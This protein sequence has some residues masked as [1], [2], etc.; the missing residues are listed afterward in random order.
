MKLQKEKLPW[1][2]VK[3]HEMSSEK[4]ACAICALLFLCSDFL[5][6]DALTPITPGRFQFLLTLDVG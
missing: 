5:G 2:S 4:V 6:A 3:A 1:K